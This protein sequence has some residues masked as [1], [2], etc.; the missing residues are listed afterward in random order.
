[1]ILPKKLQPIT[2][3]EILKEVS[4]ELGI[5]QKDVDRTY[6]I[7]LEFLNH[8]ANETDQSTI[9]F[10]HIGKMYV[11]VHKMRR[12][13]VSEK[14]KKIKERKLKEIEKLRDKCEF[15]VHEKSVSIILKYGVAKRNF[16]D[17]VFNEHKPFYTPR[18]LIN[19]QNTKFFDEDKDFSES[20]K[21][22]K[23]FIDENN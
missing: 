14:L 1:M 9:A 20:K 19:K 15:I 8:I 7:W 13:L 16:I 22:I 12:N 17:H 3:K 10:P 2:E 5:N 4:K 23:Y 11:S 18:E 6:Q 21:L